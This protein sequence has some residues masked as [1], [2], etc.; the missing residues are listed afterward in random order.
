MAKNH[1]FIIPKASYTWDLHLAMKTRHE[2]TTF[3]DF[4]KT[5]LYSFVHTA[6]DTKVLAKVYGGDD[7]EWQNDTGLATFNNYSKD[8]RPAMYTAAGYNAAGWATRTKCND[9]TIPAPPSPPA[10]NTPPQ[11]ADGPYQLSEG[12]SPWLRRS[13][14][15]NINKIVVTNLNDSGAGSLRNALTTPGPRE[16]VFDSSLSGKIWLSNKIRI[17]SLNGERDFLWLTGSPTVE[18]KGAPLEFYGARYIYIRDLIC[19]P[20]SQEEGEDYVTRD[21][22]SFYSAITQDGGRTFRDV[23]IQNSILDG[24]TDECLSFFRGVCSDI[25]VIGCKIGPGKSNKEDKNGNPI[26]IVE[27]SGT[28]SGTSSMTARPTV[29]RHDEPEDRGK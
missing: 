5:C 22:I 17:T 21:C 24:G 10:L 3:Q 1:Y 27:L 16:V 15:A 29:I 6:G 26:R 20:G 25:W 11:S 23:C 8:Q 18:V 14:F 7:V 12:A 4:G 9:P 28:I 19:R 13:P 2:N